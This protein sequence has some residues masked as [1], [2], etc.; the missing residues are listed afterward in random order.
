MP[1][2]TLTH[3]QETAE[4]NFLH[5]QAP[6]TLVETAL[7]LAMIFSPVCLINGQKSLK[8]LQSN[9][10]AGYRFVRIGATLER[11]TDQFEIRPLYEVGK[12][13]FDLKTMT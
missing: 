5:R 2:T 7:A 13:V 6:L 1:P 9:H 3:R 12:Q 10:R 11:C 4:N 8:T